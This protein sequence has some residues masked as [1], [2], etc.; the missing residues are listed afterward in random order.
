[1]TDAPPKTNGSAGSP[2]PNSTA[3]IVRGITQFIRDLSFENPGNRPTHNQPE[4]SLGVDVG[5][6][7]IQDNPNTYEV[8]LKIRASAKTDDTP[9][10]LIELEYAGI[11][12]LEGIPEDQL[13]P[14]LYI[15]CARMIF[16]FARQIVA[17]ITRDGGFPPLLLD[18]VDFVTLY[19]EGKAK[20][21]A[22]AAST[23][24]SSLQI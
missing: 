7:A 16:P 2:K 4:M 17:T 3:P 8:I 11:F 15:E 22:A 5:A 6:N 14:L 23:P 1:M 9:L 21:T 12:H 10:F 20:Q 13:E 18:P 19:R 24:K